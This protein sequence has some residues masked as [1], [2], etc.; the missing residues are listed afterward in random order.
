MPGPGKPFAKGDPRR[1]KGGRPSIPE[2]FREK[3]RKIV[4]ELVLARWQEEVDSLGEHWVKCSE[5]LTAYGYGKPA[6][7]VTGENGEGSVQVQL[8]RVIVLPAKDVAK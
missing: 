2:A 5:L 3:A 8:S 7:P 1:A 4:D 6:Q